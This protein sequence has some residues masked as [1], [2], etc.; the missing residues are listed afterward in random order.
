MIETK[1]RNYESQTIEYSIIAK[2]FLRFYWH[3]IC[4]YKIKQNPNPSKLPIIVQIVHRIFGKE[5]IPESFEKMDKN[6][7]QQA[8]VQITEECFREVIPRFQNIPNGIDVVE[9]KVFYEYYENVK[10]I[11]L[12]PEAI[13]YFKEN[14]TLLLKATMLEC[15]KFLERINKGL[16]MLISKIEGHSP[17]R[18]SLE[19]TRKI[20][21]IYFDRCFYCNNPL[22]QDKR[23]VQVDHVI[24][25]SYIYEDEIWNLVL[26][27][28]T[29][30]FREK[31]ARFHQTSL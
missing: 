2:A 9:K 12:K 25:W 22:S 23:M 3:Q 6:K 8:E 17:D 26:S 14:H 29:C 4:A 7:I 11:A 15:A 27:C 20:L 30:N 13:K 31:L 21:S 10:K 1:I 18:G 28:K 16:P 5:Y 19:N 24:P